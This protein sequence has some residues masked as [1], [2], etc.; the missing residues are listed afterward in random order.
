MLPPA[1][2]SSAWAADMAPLLVTSPPGAR[3]KTRSLPSASRSSTSLP[4]ASAA[5]PCGA[6]MLPVLVTVRAISTTSPLAER[7]ERRGLGLRGSRAVLPASRR[8]LSPLAAKWQR[9]F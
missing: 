3:T 2:L 7:I 5:V 6:A 4:A 8:F 9:K 1:A